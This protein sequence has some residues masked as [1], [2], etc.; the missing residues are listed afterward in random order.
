AKVR[1]A[2]ARIS[3]ADQARSHAEAAS[4]TVADTLAEEAR[5]REVAD[6]H[7]AAAAAHAG[8]LADEL[9]AANRKLDA[10][11]AEAQQLRRAHQNL[12]TGPVEAVHR[13]A[14]VEP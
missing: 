3:E 9:A 2:W 7:A 12:A 14:A 13:A 5:R 8:Q 1:D 10:V 4:A 11:N 6:R